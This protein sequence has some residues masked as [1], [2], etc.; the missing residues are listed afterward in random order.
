MRIFWTRFAATFIMLHSVVLASAAALGRVLPPGQQ[1]AYAAYAGNESAGDYDIF[2]MDVAHHLSV[3]LTQYPLADEQPA[4]SPDGT[5]IAFISLRDDTF[6]NLYLMD[7]EG[8][9]L[10]RLTDH[11]NDVSLPVW[12]PDGEKI[13]YLVASDPLN[14]LYIFDLAS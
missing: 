1:L 4:W 5:Q 2:R 8:H 9:N 7:S 6:K 11:D 3:N 10:R 13:A 12:S 14:G